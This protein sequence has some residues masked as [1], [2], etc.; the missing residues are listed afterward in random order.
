MKSG[1]SGGAGEGT[2]LPIRL[3]GSGMPGLWLPCCLHRHGASVS[4]CVSLMRTLVT[5]LIQD[6]FISRSFPLLLFSTYGHMHSPEPTC[7]LGVHCPIHNRLEGAF[8]EKF[9]VAQIWGLIKGP[10]VDDTTS[11]SCLS[12]KRESRAAHMDVAPGSPSRPGQ[13]ALLV[14]LC[15]VDGQPASCGLS[16]TCF[17]LRLPQTCDLCAGAMV[18]HWQV[19][20]PEKHSSERPLVGREFDC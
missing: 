12:W 13:T 15:L 8:S 5:Q 19:T 16:G 9:K 2:L 10:E 11:R 18:G 7:I 14:S 6:D 3:P 20:V 1:S 4:P 17:L